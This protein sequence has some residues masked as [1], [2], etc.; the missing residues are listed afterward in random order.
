MHDDQQ[1]E[2]TG[3]HHAKHVAGKHNQAKQPAEHRHEQ[4]ECHDWRQHERCRA[5]HQGAAGRG[6]ENKGGTGYQL[7]C[8]PEQDEC[9]GGNG[10]AEG[11][12]TVKTV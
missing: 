11:P 4:Q 8:K 9:R 10:N 1:A 5:E 3:Q 6:L 2:E 12:A 7:R